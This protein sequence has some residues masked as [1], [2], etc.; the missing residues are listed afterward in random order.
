MC[1]VVLKALDTTC[2][3]PHIL[4]MQ[5]QCESERYPKATDYTIMHAHC[6]PMQARP[7]TCTVAAWEACTCSFNYSAIHDGTCLGPVQH[8]TA[9]N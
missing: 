7:C 9:S 5:D 8:D 6:E 1:T 2:L 4:S 3:M